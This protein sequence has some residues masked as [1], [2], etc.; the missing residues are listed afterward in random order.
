MAIQQLSSP[1]SPL[2][3]TEAGSRPRQAGL[4]PDLLGPS[5]AAPTCKQVS[6]PMHTSFALL[7]CLYP[8]ANPPKASTPSLPTG[9]LQ[10][11]ED[12]VLAPR[13]QMIL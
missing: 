3:S 11:S 12:P 9:L 13:H 10:A 6:D 1:S 5:P 4:N 7:V 8:N 2:T